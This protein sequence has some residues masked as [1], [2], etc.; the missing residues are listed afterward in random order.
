MQCQSTLEWTI[1]TCLLTL[2]FNILFNSLYNQNTN[3]QVE[4]RPSARKSMWT[5]LQ[6]ICKVRKTSFITQVNA[7]W[8]TTREVC[9]G[10]WPLRSQLRSQ[11]MRMRLPPA[12]SQRWWLPKT[13]LLIR[14]SHLGKALFWTKCMSRQICGWILLFLIHNMREGEEMN[15][16]LGYILLFLEVCT[17]SFKMSLECH[18]YWKLKWSGRSGKK[19]KISS[20]FS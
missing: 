17:E 12:P 9:A 20:P 10:S 1:S 4:P 13:V 16:F 2:V 15:N 11:K 8:T 18:H 7:L 14:M 19:K 5:Q 6:P 3:R